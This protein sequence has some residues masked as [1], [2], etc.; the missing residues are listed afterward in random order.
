M[1]PNKQGDLLCLGSYV[2]KNPHHDL[3][4]DFIRTYW[5]M[6]YQAGLFDVT[7]TYKTHTS[8]RNYISVLSSYFLDLI[9]IQALSVPKII[10]ILKRRY[11]S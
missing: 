1:G 4:L 2:G 8:L 3:C 5:A 9:F 6:K 11:I 7:D 10:F